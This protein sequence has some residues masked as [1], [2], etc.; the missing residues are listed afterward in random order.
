MVPPANPAFIRLSDGKVLGTPTAAV[1]EDGIRIAPLPTRKP[2]N[3]RPDAVIV[4]RP[5]TAAD[6]KADDARSDRGLTARRA[7]P[8]ADQQV[9]R[10]SRTG[11]DEP[12]AS[13][14]A[15]VDAGQAATPRPAAASAAVGGTAGAGRTPAPAGPGPPA[16]RAASTASPADP[17]AP[18]ARPAARRLGRAAAHRADPDHDG[19]LGLR[20]TA[21]PAPGHRRGRLRRQGRGRGRRGQRRPAGDA[22]LDHRPQRRPRSPSPSTG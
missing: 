8:R 3:L 7:R 16:G 14:G 6:D 13:R 21:L 18:P 15:S 9:Q 4:P 10:T 11:R 17:P 20:R 2:R 19:R 5:R 1:P 22:R 12:Q